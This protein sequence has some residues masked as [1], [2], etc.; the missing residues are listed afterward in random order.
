M[1]PA[2]SDATALPGT[3]PPRIAQRA[4]AAQWGGILAVQPHYF[5]SVWEMVQ[6]LGVDAVAARMR[7]DRKA[8][9]DGEA[10]ATQ[11]RLPYQMVG[12]VAAIQVSGPI[13]KESN[14]FGGASTVEARL[15]IES[16]LRDPAVKGI[17]L[18][19]D[20]PGGSV[21][22]VGDLADDIHAANQVK[23]LVAYIED[24]GASAAYWL[25][26]QAGKV[27][28]SR[29]AE[30][31]SIGVYSAIHDSSKAA[32]DAGVKAYLVTSGGIKG[33]GYPGTKVPE[34]AIASLQKQVDGVNDLFLEAIM[35]GRGLTAEQAKAINTGETW[36]A[37]EA[38]RLGLI[39]GVAPLRRVLASMQG[40]VAPAK[41]Q[42]PIAATISRLIPAANAAGSG[43]TSA[44]AGTF[45]TPTT[46]GSFTIDANAAPPL[47]PPNVDSVAVVQGLN[48]NE[49]LH[50]REGIARNDEKEEHDMTTPLTE[51]KEA[52]PA[53][54]DSHVDVAGIEARLLAKMEEQ[55][56]ARMEAQQKAATA[57]RVDDLREQIA[58]RRGVPIEKLASFK[59]EASLMAADEF[60]AGARGNAR[61]VSL[62]DAAAGGHMDALKAL[63]EDREKFIRSITI[64]RGA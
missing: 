28:A 25:A 42:G 2:V 4:C 26:S 15:A 64:K 13:S 37:K 41:V 29:H 38:Q 36:G 60:L 56:N 57:K 31:G 49:A 40:G 17:L 48:T 8:E 63:D 47:P 7:A 46:T 62:G 50:G 55:L 43:G 35:R 1:V 44:I 30:V 53:S 24:T 54:G 34:Q 58:L 3:L 11:S 5:S 16:A 23:P 19:I 20:S 45:T 22:G 61:G 51:K 6:R 52:A 27:Y 14:S 21:A 59:D 12:D 39:D 10:G 32:E 18:H 33:A 9:V